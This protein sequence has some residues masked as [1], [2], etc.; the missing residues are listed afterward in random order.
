[1]TDEQ[2]EAV[3]LV[4]ETDAVPVTEQPDAVPVAEQ[5][6][7]VP[8][9]EQPVP[10]SETDPA[11]ETDPVAVKK[12]WRRG[13][14]AAVA[15]AVLLVAAVVGGVGHTVV[16]VQ[17]ADRDAGAPTWTLPKAAKEAKAAKAAS[18]LAAM[19]VP[20]GT[21]DWTPGPD[22]GEFGADAVLGGRE[23]TALRKE[24]LSELPRSERKRL[25]E[26][27]DKQHT[28]GI[29]MRSYLS[30]SDPR[31]F[32]YSTVSIELSQIEDKAV[33]KDMSTFQ[34]ELLDAFK[35]FR[36]GPE[37]KG[38]KDAKCFLQPK[39]SEEKLDMMLCSA[40]RGEVLVNVTATGVKPLDTKGV[41][42]LL[43]VQL[44]R[45]AEP[46]EAV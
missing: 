35:I 2:S 6:E 32:K 1:V 9:A 38:H 12:P 7:A 30:T 25:E 28:K 45:I 20:Y 14:I 36:K 39:D 40:Y 22:I 29:A 37:I 34:N 10:A 18:G 44:D 15:G 26:R 17:D 11:P 23:A 19:L 46:G 31:D 4:E 43:G 16:T 13:R 5:S 21:D 24:S 3:P 27:I 8:R 33:V 42:L 41:A